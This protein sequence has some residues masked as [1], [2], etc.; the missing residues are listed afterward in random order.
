[1]PTNTTLRRFFGH[2]LNVLAVCT[3]GNNL[4]TASKDRSMKQFDLVTGTCVRTFMGHTD[5]VTSLHATDGEQLG[6]PPG[7]VILLS[8]SADKTVRMWSV[9]TGECLQVCAGHA[10]EV[11]AV[12]LAAGD[13]FSSSTDG[14]IKRWDYRSGQCIMQYRGT[15][16]TGNAVWCLA[17]N[18]QYVFGGNDDGTVRQYD[19]T[20]G[21]LSRTY[22]RHQ[23][24]VLS[25]CTV[26]TQR[27]GIFKQG[28]LCTGS[29]DGTIKLWRVGGPELVGAS[30]VGTSRQGA[31]AIHSV[32]ANSQGAVYAGC[33]GGVVSEYD[34]NAGGFVDQ[35]DGS[36]LVLTETHEWKGNNG[37]IMGMAIMEEGYLFTASE[38]CTAHEF[39]VK[40]SRA[41]VTQQP[42]SAAP[43][44][45]RAAPSASRSG[46][47]AAEPYVDPSLHNARSV[48]SPMRRVDPS[49]HLKASTRQ[50]ANPTAGEAQLQA[51]L[52]SRGKG[53]ALDQDERA[54]FETMRAQQR[55]MEEYNRIL[56]E[57]L[58]ALEGR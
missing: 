42:Q 13:L 8:G 43:R 33:S 31:A 30:C 56:E 58:R 14:T 24:S 26:D 32:T 11:T 55:K 49:L 52:A 7:S 5:W 36:E 2:R 17:T 40:G 45:T 20:S 12:K 27:R 54:E 4:F 3:Y 37:A 15:H 19:I 29:A 38:D 18:G 1:M 28:L 23:G 35:A 48:T 34:L 53:R 10:G 46:Y 50:A 6:M 21:D 16:S 9:T 57:K 44:R 47:Q 39:W 25:I 41:A 51:M 22:E